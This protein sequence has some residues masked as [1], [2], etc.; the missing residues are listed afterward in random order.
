MP[1]RITI[2]VSV[3][4]LVGAAPYDIRHE[5]WRVHQRLE[6]ASD[7]RS[8]QELATLPAKDPDLLPED[9]WIMPFASSGLVTYVISGES[10]EI[11]GVELP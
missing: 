8:W 4:R 9:S 2:H 1:R 11:V 5:F 3:L 7:L 10:V 6:E